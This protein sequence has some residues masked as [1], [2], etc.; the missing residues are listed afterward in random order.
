MCARSKALA[1]CHILV[2]KPFTFETPDT[3]RPLTLS[4]SPQYPP[5]FPITSAMRR[6]SFGKRCW[7]QGGERKSKWLE[8]VYKEELTNDLFPLVI[9]NL[10]LPK[11]D[12]RGNGQPGALVGD[13]VPVLGHPE[14]RPL[15]EAEQP[16]WLLY[17]A[18]MAET[19][20]RTRDTF[21]LTKQLF[22]LKCDVREQISLTELR[23]L[24]SAYTNTINPIRNMYKTGIRIERRLRDQTRIRV[25]IGRKAADDKA[26][27]AAES[28]LLANKEIEQTAENM[29]TVRT[30][31]TSPIFAYHYRLITNTLCSA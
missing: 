22:K 31:I 18:R 28:A 13:T 4:Q 24:D 2:K 19:F 25:Q 17:L 6:W 7:V 9:D 3:R 8:T 16:Q 1:N 11:E 27:T 26:F 12:A 23:L 30:T 29:L 21:R 10:F 5:C 20:G 14:P 15:T